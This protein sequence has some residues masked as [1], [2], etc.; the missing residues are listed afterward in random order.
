MLKRLYFDIETSLIEAY[1]WHLGKQVIGPEQIKNEACILCIAYKW[2]DEEKVHILDFTDPEMLNKFAWVL[3]QADEVA[4]HNGKNFDLRWVMWEMLKARIPAFPTYKV[5][6][7]LTM[8]RNKFRAPSNRLNYL[9][10]VLFGKKKQET[11][12]LPLWIQVMEGDKNAL[13][14][15]KSYCQQDVLLLEELHNLIES[16]FP[17][18]TNRAILE[19]KAKWC[20]AYCASN[21][22]FLSKTRVTAAGTVKRQLFCKDCQHYFSV[23]DSIYQKYLEEKE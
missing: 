21:N 20:C 11:G 16:Y 17:P 23:S 9:T 12:G 1:I 22:V 4:G 19:G 3:D 14:L 5:V 8:M 2:N 10:K 13:K 7:T 15:M 18:Q 6:D